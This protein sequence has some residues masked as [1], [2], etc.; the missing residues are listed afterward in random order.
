MPPNLSPES[1]TLRVVK[2]LIS[3]SLGAAERSRL[4]VWLRA[5]FDP[6]SG[7]L[8]ASPWEKR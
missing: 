3:N 4:I 8:N 2:T 5:K 7:E 6:R 1:D